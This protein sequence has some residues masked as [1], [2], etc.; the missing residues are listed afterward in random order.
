MTRGEIV[1]AVLAGDYGKV[2]PA[3]VLQSDLLAEI[4]SIIICPLSSSLSRLTTVR[5]RLAPD[6]ATGLLVMSEAMVEKIGGVKRDRV[7]AVL[8]RVSDET[9]REIEAKLLFVLGL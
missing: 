7:R 9:M 2:R 3:V 1:L 4:D 5:V 6:P 8:G